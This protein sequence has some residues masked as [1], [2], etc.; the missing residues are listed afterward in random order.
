MPTVKEKNAVEER[1]HALRSETF[2][3]QGNM[4]R[5]TGT[6]D[7][8]TWDELSREQ[9]LDVLS[10]S[11]DWSGFDVDQ[12]AEVSLRAVDDDWDL[13]LMED[14]P[15]SDQREHDRADALE[16]RTE[17]WFG[18]YGRLP[19][20]GELARHDKE[21]REFSEANPPGPDDTLD[22]APRASSW[23]EESEFRESEAS[24]LGQA[25]FDP[26]TL[27][28]N[29]LVQTY[30]LNRDIGFVG[31]R[32]EFMNDPGIVEEWPDPADRER[33]LRDFFDERSDFDAYCQDFADLDLPLLIRHQDDLLALRDG[34][35]EAQIAY[36]RRGRDP[37]GDGRET[38]TAANDNIPGGD[39]KP[40]GAPPMSAYERRLQEAAE[41]G[42]YHAMNQERDNG[43]DH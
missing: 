22:P 39:G 23:V 31:F 25:A 8:L 24:W 40:P 35:E 15:A 11:V 6:S 30:N 43:R 42:K 19:E 7:G 1:I 28:T 34:P 33:G 4:M 17:E 29:L 12:Q 36:Y 10:S 5:P 27:R 20:P 37:G 14:I 16:R 26:E 2:R 32:N 21:V 41:Q 9:A 3:M 18:Q 13:P 38:P